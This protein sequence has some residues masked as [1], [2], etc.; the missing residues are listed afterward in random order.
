MITY[1]A[2]ESMGYYA[3]DCKVFVDAKLRYMPYAQAGWCIEQSGEKRTM[4]SYS[5][6][7][8]TAT[9]W[10]GGLTIST[11]NADAAIDYSRTTSRQVTMA[12]R[13]LGLTDKRIATIKKVLT[14]PVWGVTQ[15]QVTA[16]GVQAIDGACYGRYF[17]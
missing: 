16:L 12:L 4:Y 5:S 14:A 1:T 10:A 7:I 9:V 11:E 13:E 6:A 8:F 15:V 3:K 2:H 17:G